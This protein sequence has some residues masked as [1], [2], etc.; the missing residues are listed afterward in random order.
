MLLFDNLRNGRS[1]GMSGVSCSLAWKVQC[2][3]WI[4]QC[5]P[6]H[7]NGFPQRVGWRKYPFVRTGPCI[8]QGPEPDLGVCITAYGGA[9][10]HAA[11][12][13]LLDSWGIF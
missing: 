11:K 8:S 10:Q 7:H 13:I 6:R 3:V 2:R 4:P 9:N 5:L 1:R 12:D